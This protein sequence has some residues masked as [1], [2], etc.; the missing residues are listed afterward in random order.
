MHWLAALPLSRK[1]ELPTLEILVGSSFLLGEL[2]GD[3]S[4]LTDI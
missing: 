4:I 3:I 1:R 2:L